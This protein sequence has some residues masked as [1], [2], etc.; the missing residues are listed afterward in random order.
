MRTKIITGL[1]VSV[2]AFTTVSAMEMTT[3]GA[4]MAK[5]TMM[6]DHMMKATS[7]MMKK[8]DGMMMKDKMMGNK[9]MMKSLTPTSDAGM[10]SRGD[11]VTAIQKFLIEKGFLTLPTGAVHGYYGMMTKKAVMA[12]QESIG[13]NP[14]GFFGPKTRMMMQDKMKMT[15]D[16]KMMKK[17]EAMMKDKM[18]D[19]S[20]MMKSGS[21]EVFSTDKLV[22][23]STGDVILFFKAGWCPTC[24]A[25]DSDIKGNLVKIPENVSILEVDYENSSVLKQKYGVTYQH[26]FVKVDK[27]GNLIKK[28]SGSPTLSAII[29]ES[30]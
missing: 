2:V 28:W 21:Y 3:T 9:K 12:Y 30:K 24:R 25:V 16:A 20:K 7:S 27:D 23:A 4:P 8:D 19:T 14:T 18:M 6:D 22:R 15:D 17:D 29:S 13:V 11:H 26:T 10:G 5:D 1:L